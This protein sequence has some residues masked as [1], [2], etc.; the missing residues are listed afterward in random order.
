[1]PSA[2]LPP[3]NT[4]TDPR[5]CPCCGRHNQCAQAART[6]AQDCWCMTASIAPEALAAVPAEQRGQVCLCPACAAG[7][8]S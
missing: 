4:T 2:P 1:M 8:F 5:V 7:R 3:S 6:D